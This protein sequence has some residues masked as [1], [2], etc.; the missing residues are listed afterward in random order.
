[1]NNAKAYLVERERIAYI[2]GDTETAKVLGAA[3]EH[4]CEIEE[5][6]NKA[7][8][9][10]ESKQ[11]EIDALM[12]EYCPSEMETPNGDDTRTESKTGGDEDTA[13]VS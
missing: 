4:V 6:L 12:F 2:M 3:L 9:E 13:R 10:L 11:A 7:H 5:E 1:M 8:S